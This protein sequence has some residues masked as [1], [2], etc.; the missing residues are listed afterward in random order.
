M[1]RLL[2]VTLMPTLLAA[3]EVVELGTVEV[4][5]TT[6]IASTGLPI[7]NIPANVQIITGKALEETLSLHMAD[8]M[9]RRLG[10]VIINDAQNN[11]F[12]PDVQ[13][14]G[15][16]ASPL[17]GLPQGLAVYVNGVRFNEPF[18]DTFH[19]DLIPEGAIARMEVHP[20]SDPVYGL[21][22]LGG[23]LALRLRTAFTQAP[24]HQFEFYGGSFERRN[25]EG[26]STWNNGQFGYF[27][28]LRKFEEDGWREESPTRVRQLYSAASFRSGRAEAN[29]SFIVTDNRMIGNGAIPIQLYREDRNTYFTRPDE[30]V[31]RLFFVNFDGRLQI[32]D[33]LELAGVAYFRNSR[34]RTFNGDDSDFEQCDPPDDAFLCDDEGE[35]VE[36][37][38]GNLVR[39]S[40]AVEGGTQNL[41]TTRQKGYGTSFQL[42]FTRELLGMENHFVAG[43]SFD[44]ARIDFKFDT[45]LAQLTQD[46]ATVG[47]GILVD[48]S[49][50]RLDSTVTHLSGYFLEAL[51]PFEGLTLMVSGRYNNTELDLHDNWG[52][53]LN[54]HH[55]FD[56][57]NPAAGLTYNWFP[58]LSIYGRYSTSNRAPTAVELTC[59]DPEAP[60]RLPNAFVA[61]PPLKQVFARSFEA[62]LR[63]TL[64]RRSRWFQPI[65]ERFGIDRINW[66]AGFFHTTNHDDIVFISALGRTGGFF[67]NVDK[68]R[69][70]G[71][72]GNFDLS[73]LKGRIHLS[74]NYTYLDATFQD[75]FFVASPNN[76]SANANGL[77]FVE[78]GDR[79]PLLPR[80]I[81]KF[82]IDVEPIRGL[83]LGFDG[84]YTSD[85][86]FRGDEANLNDPLSDFWVFNLNVSYSPHR[87]V[88]LFLRVE[89]L[90]DKNYETF[91]V[92]GEADEVLGERFDDPRFVGPGAERGL[93]GGV[94]VQF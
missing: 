6:P 32:T 20:G 75:S 35:I 91:G 79:I 65:R 43:F 53:E 56:R 45:E 29:L 13:F 37:V 12:Q 63:G 66:H 38:Q 94:R 9:R 48:E 80:H 15:F 87:S 83:K 50:V 82:A 30:T 71:M 77:I 60:C 78:E 54:G 5:G 61:D 49:R 88:A 26:S 59:A 34:I 58:A 39:F 93:W 21:N 51:S 92:Y 36:D 25:F 11:P 22:A 73:A 85:R 1:R 2:V 84:V 33:D 4:V 86:Y 46:R 41:S 31:N 64:D 28:H 81:F 18:G 68:T 55:T 72:E 7:E 70:L 27:V 14:R 44:E 10:S 47:S 89:N 52:S 42:T 74:V 69:R 62:G 19:W 16:V 57:F 23:A 3:D 67:T 17:L 40:E 24:F 8:Y 76:P 90:F